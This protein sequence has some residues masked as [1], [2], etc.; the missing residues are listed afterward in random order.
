MLYSCTDMATVDVK[1]LTVC[2]KRTESVSWCVVVYRA[3]TE[4]VSRAARDRV[5]HYL[6]SLRQY[7]AGFDLFSVARVLL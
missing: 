2:C 1:G 4:I 5:G 7:F 3:G 6:D